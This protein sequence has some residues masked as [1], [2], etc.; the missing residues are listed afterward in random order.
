MKFK[1][2]V[3]ITVFGV[4]AIAMVPK[5]I[6]LTAVSCSENKTTTEPATPTPE[7]PN[8]GDTTQPKPPV[9]VETITQA[10]YL[11]AGQILKNSI[12]PVIN[13]PAA[14]FANEIFQGVSSKITEIATILKLPATVATAKPQPLPPFV[15]NADFE[16]GESV[17]MTVQPPNDNNW[18][19]VQVVVQYWYNKATGLP[20]IDNSLTDF[21]KLETNNGLTGYSVTFLPFQPTTITESQYDNAQAIVTRNLGHITTKP[22][23]STYVNE[24][25]NVLKDKLETILTSV[26]LS[27]SPL[28]NHPVFVPPYQGYLN[29]QG[30]VINE[31]QG[32][33][34]G[35]TCLMVDANNN[36]IVEV[37]YV[38][39]V[40]L[41][42]VS[43]NLSTKVSSINEDQIT[44]YRF[45][46]S[47]NV[48]KPTTSTINK[49]QLASAQ[50]IIT[51]SIT[52][53]DKNA[54]NYSDLVK[55][56][57]TPKL[58]EIVTC[59]GL[60]TTE[61]TIKP[62]T[63]APEDTPLNAQ[64]QFMICNGQTYLVVKDNNLIVQIYYVNQSNLPTIEAEI[65]HQINF[66]TGENNAARYQLTFAL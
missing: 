55:Q 51:Q 35:E 19:H 48:V 50:S 21:V 40:G 31:P 26:G 53:L 4:F 54:A 34:N 39:Q 2:K 61:L 30:Q 5:T 10:D 3:L 22:S 17:I 27:S 47:N 16:N 32:V 45:S 64:G 44:A 37:Y 29:D 66:L 41:P 33:S 13:H 42:T 9:K 24:V 1:N 18:Y 6:A 36:I 65:H 23:D 58:N 25:R 38:D 28:T 46:F 20:T 52:G 62:L 11:K 57:I 43:D 63:V 56:A 15:K 14:G 8:P 60:P 7:I 59:L 12:A 49:T